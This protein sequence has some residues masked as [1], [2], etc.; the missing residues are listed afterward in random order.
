M[1]YLFVRVRVLCEILTFYIKNDKKKTVVDHVDRGSLIMRTVEF[2]TIHF[3]DM[4]IL[5]FQ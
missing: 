1:H 5:L 4:L 2:S 3:F